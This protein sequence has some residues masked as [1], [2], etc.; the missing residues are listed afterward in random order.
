MTARRCLPYGE[1]EPCA[2]G[3][4]QRG[5]AGLAKVG[6]AAEN[7]ADAGVAVADRAAGADGAPVTARAK[8]RGTSRDTVRM[9]RSWF[10][11]ASPEIRIMAGWLVT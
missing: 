3:A 11:Q 5:T 6:A 4:E 9:W 1:S 8:D 10:L 7:R 2:A